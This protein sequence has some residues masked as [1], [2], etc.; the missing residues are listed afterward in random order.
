VGRAC[1]GSGV[2]RFL[3]EGREQ[4]CTGCSERGALILGDGPDPGEGL[5]SGVK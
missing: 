3:A 1:L 2:G 4:R 5:Q